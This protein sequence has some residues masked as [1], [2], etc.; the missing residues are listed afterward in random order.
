MT[1]NWIHLLT[2]AIIGGGLALG[3]VH[4]VSSSRERSL[5]SEARDRLGLPDL[6]PGARILYAHHNK[7][8]IFHE[9]YGFAFEADA[10][11]VEQWVA[12]ARECHGETQ[13]DHPA[14]AFH[15][16]ALVDFSASI[17]G[18]THVQVQL[19]FDYTRNK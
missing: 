5:V 12:Q 8:E 4:L 11:A 3:L 7:P 17:R 2:G 10:A 18:S 1:R 6:P 16:R 15:A 14:G 19:Q 9:W 13:R